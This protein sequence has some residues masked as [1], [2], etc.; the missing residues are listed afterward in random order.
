VIP[1][2]LRHEYWVGFSI[3]DADAPERF[4]ILLL[5]APILALGVG[6]LS[7]RLGI[8]PLRTSNR[9]R[10]P[11]PSPLTSPLEESPYESIPLPSI[12]LLLGRLLPAAQPGEAYLTTLRSRR[13]SAKT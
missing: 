11:T 2:S 8:A 4:G 10:E 5:W 7:A 6:G 9:S 12:R 13:R 1:P 3:A